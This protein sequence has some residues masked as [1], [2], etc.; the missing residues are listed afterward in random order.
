MLK[1]ARKVYRWGQ[2]LS[3]F[4]FS[5]F[6]LA[7]IVFT[8]C[9]N[10]LEGEQ[11]QTKI[12][13]AIEYANA[14]YA[15]IT[16]NS[17]NTA[18]ETIIPATGN[19]NNKYKKT[20][21]FNINFKPSKN[22]QFVKWVA[23][24]E[25]SVSFENER[26]LSTVVTI[27]N[28]DK[29]ISIEPLVYER[30]QFSIAPVNVVENPK[31][32]TIVI[33]STTP[34]DISLEDL[35]RISITIDDISI[36]ENYQAPYFNKDKTTITFV[37][38]REN[39][40]DLQSGVKV[41]KISIPADFYYEKDNV[42][43]YL[44]DDFNYSFKINS[45]TETDVE[46]TVSCPSEKG[47]LSYT[48]TKTYYLDN[49][50]SIKCTQKTGYLLRGW[51]AIYNDDNSVVEENILEVKVSEDGSEAFVK[52]L[53]GS[54]R[55]ISFIPFFKERGFV[56]VIF[57]TNHGYT[58]PSDKK[59]YYVDDEFTVSYREETGFAFTNWQVENSSG[60]I[61]NDVLEIVD[62]NAA[63]TTCKVLKESSSLKLV[64]KNASRPKVVNISPSYKNTGDYR[65]SRI[66][67]LFGEKMSEKA[68]YWT[69][70]ELIAEGIK[71][72]DY[73]YLGVESNN[74]YYGYKKKG[75]DGDTIKY[76]NIEICE[77]GNAE[78]NFLKYYGEPF[79]ESSN[80]TILVIPAIGDGV[81]QY[82]YVSIILKPSFCS[83]NL[84]PINEEKNGYFLT[85]ASTDD[86]PPEVIDVNMTIGGKDKVK[87]SDVKANPEAHSETYKENWKGLDKLPI[88]INGTFKD[89]GSQLASLQIKMTPIEK[90]YPNQEM[91]EYIET[92]KLVPG[93]DGFCNFTDANPLD[94]EIELKDKKEGA[95][96]IAFSCFD[97][98]NNE[99]SFGDEYVF[100]Y[101]YNDGISPNSITAE[102][103]YCPIKEF[104]DSNLSEA[105]VGLRGVSNFEYKVYFKD[106]NKDKAK[107]ISSDTDLNLND[108]W[109]A[110][111]TKPSE[112]NKTLQMHVIVR[113]A[114][115]EYILD[116]IEI[117]YIGNSK[118]SVSK[119]SI[120]NR[121]TSLT[122][123]FVP[124]GDCEDIK[125]LYTDIKNTGTGS[126]C[127]IIGVGVFK[128]MIDVK[129]LSSHTDIE[130]DPV[131]TPGSGGSITFSTLFRG[132]SYDAPIKGTVQFEDSKG[133]K[134]EVFTV[135]IP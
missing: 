105:K 40:I 37:P 101:I 36:L 79:F 121:G 87:F 49:E 55:S 77:L 6:L 117:K 75:D 60:N 104:K 35:K 100:V 54:E 10:F 95:Y 18:T 74:R 116:P 5:L 23:N 134:S 1:K 13:A 64:A 108:I 98:K 34:L 31:N 52:V 19:Y 33:T 38:K 109:D 48:G 132:L 89:A 113:D 131:L 86:L 71:D 82:K 27:T 62:S 51:N 15:D 11:V 65:D 50:F 59:T 112:E 44:T 43:I 106:E 85:N 58:I 124:G 88:S 126:S 46:I 127:I 70:E 42:K 30:P 20:D 123:E 57:D 16:I 115:E 17:L 12:E 92:V 56:E 73:D 118:V 128:K 78:N 130:L 45:T 80:N 3:F 83:A 97:N 69:K 29:P 21:K 103:V 28:I 99:K 93:S 66:T 96:K 47:N 25:G 110:G 24:P 68:I 63:E 2:T 133:N 102:S 53:T 111:D 120:P 84:I 14:L 94:I 7:T 41:V 119:E 61:I 129:P 4:V 135:D 72:T 107:W 122:Y 91:Q 90:M 39:L 125:Y 26:D 81:P 67:I 22:Y 9:E 8:S 76:K 114:F 32:S